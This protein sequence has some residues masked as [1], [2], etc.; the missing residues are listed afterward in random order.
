L[1]LIIHGGAGAG[2]NDDI[3]AQ[4]LIIIIHI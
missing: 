2:N 3:F 1:K 4:N